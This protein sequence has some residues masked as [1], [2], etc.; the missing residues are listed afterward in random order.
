MAKRADSHTKKLN[1]DGGTPRPRREYKPFVP[2]PNPELSAFVAK[3]STP[4][5]PATDKYDV[6]AFD[7]DIAVDKA[8]PPK[9]IYDMHT[10]W[11]KKHWAAIR[12]YI[13]H[14]LPEKYYPK[15]TGLVLDCFSGS[16]MTGVA[17]MM[18]NRPCVL[19]DASPAAAFISHCYTHP[20]DPDELQSAYERMMSEPYPEELRVKLKMA[21]GENIANLKEELD[22]LYATKCDRCGG[23]ATTEYVVYSERFQCPKCG[24]L[25]ALFDCPEEKVLFEVGTAKKPKT[26][27]KKKLVCPHCLKAYGK[28]HRDFVISSREKKFGSVPMKVSYF[29]GEKCNPSR[30]ERVHS[31]KKSSRMA[32]IF[33]TVDL[34]KLEQIE[35]AELPHWFPNRNMMD[36]E[37]KGKPWGVKWRAG[38][39][40][41]RTVAE[42]YTKRNLWALSAL[43]TALIKENSSDI[44]RLSIV[45]MALGTSRMNRYVPGHWSIQNRIMAGTYYV[46]QMSTAVNILPQF[47]KRLDAISRAE[48]ALLPQQASRNRSRTNRY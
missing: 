31:E 22:W 44:L 24:E 32:K 34:K 9:A 27:L 39:S 10:Y 36:I 40:N 1:L 38:T 30:A 29:C 18:E 7:R 16:G 3:H 45:S 14:Y 13:Q 21:T 41:F 15:G 12:E 37:D 35:D 46:P 25:V 47:V 20:V 42:L 8:A 5:D 11:S 19:I 2:G 26:E 28:A 17:A 4:Y 43:V 6:K 48:D 23:E 33:E